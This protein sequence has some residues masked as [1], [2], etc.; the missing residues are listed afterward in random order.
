MGGGSG[1]PANSATM[2]GA[3]NGTAYGG[4]AKCSICGKPDGHPIPRTKRSAYHAENQAKKAPPNMKKKKRKGY[5]VASL[6]C[7]DASNRLVII[8][9]ASSGGVRAGFTPKFSGQCKTAGGRPITPGDH[10]VDGSNEGGACAAA[11]AILKANAMGLKI[12]SM[13]EVWSGPPNSNFKTG[14][15]TDSCDTCKELLPLLL[16]DKP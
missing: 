7:K 9:G 14:Q 5:M 16:C 6:V 12:E 1:S 11:Q 13:T 15:H 2:K 8:S 4:E 3:I 10:T